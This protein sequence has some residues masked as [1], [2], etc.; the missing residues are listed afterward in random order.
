MKTKETDE[1]NHIGNVVKFTLTFLYNKLDDAGGLRR[2][3]M[4]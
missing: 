4:D 3:M 2:M 1:N